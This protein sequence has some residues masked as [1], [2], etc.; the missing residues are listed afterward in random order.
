VWAKPSKFFL[1]VSVHYL[2]LAWALTLLPQRARTSWP[3]RVASATLVF[4]ALFELS[5]ITVQGARAEPSHFSGSPLGFIMFR[6]MGIAAM[7]M[8]A[9]TGLIGA[10]LLRLG[11]PKVCALV[12][13]SVALGFVAS[14]IL[15]GLSGIYMAIHG[16]HWVGGVHSDAGGLPLLHWSTCGGD[17]R[18]A[19]FFGLHTMQALPVVAWLARHEP[20]S[21]QRVVT[22]A[23]AA[24]IVLTL[25][26]FVQALMG[27]PLISA[28]G[29]QLPALGQ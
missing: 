24:W 5:Y 2:T 1:S 18:V 17:L 7:T 26:V 8:V 9:I 13:R 25:A 12:L 4:C 11:C 28:P 14:A 16:S 10:G 22:A 21:G 15:G 3:L 23:L 29:C 27:H 19:H 20:E 6:L